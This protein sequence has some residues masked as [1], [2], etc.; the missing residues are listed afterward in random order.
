MFEAAIVG[1]SGYTGGELLRLLTLHPEV[2]VTQIT[3]ERLA[4]K[5]VTRAHPNLR[6]FT[7]LKFSRLEDLSSCDLLF[8]CLPH[9]QGAV[10]WDEFKGLAPRIIDMSADYRLNDEAAYR[11]YYKDHHPRP[12]LLN[13]FTY[14]I[15]ELHR[16]DIK[17]AHYVACAGCNATVT[18]L[19]LYPLFHAGLIDINRSVVDVKVGSSEGGNRSSDASHHPERSG[20]LRSFAPVGHRHVAEIKQELGFGQNLNVHFSVTSVEMVRGALA[21]CHVFPKQPITEKD[22][23]RLYREYYGAEPFMRIVKEREGIYRYPEP[24]LLAGTNFCDVG[25]ALDASGERLVVIGAIDNLVKGSAGQ[26]VQNMNL[27]LGFQENLGL[28]FPGLHP[29]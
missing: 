8:L 20:C 11:Y 28:E 21:T 12:E 9:G 24:K 7:K 10:R 27:M 16:D 15:A 13:Q 25:F 23:W 4:G 1:G 14:G 26:A 29:V 5:P 2:N 18:I 19:S 6:G 3:S 22:V 17:N